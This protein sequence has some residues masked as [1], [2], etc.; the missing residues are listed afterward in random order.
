M[1][2][3]DTWDSAAIKGYGQLTWV[4]GALAMLLKSA[5]ACRAEATAWCDKL[6]I[7]YRIDAARESSVNK[8]IA[9]RYEDNFRYDTPRV[10][11]AVC[12]HTVR[13]WYFQKLS[14]AAVHSNQIS[15]PSMFASVQFV[16]AAC[17]LPQS[18]VQK[19]KV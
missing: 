9:K 5:V 17:L 19:V 13:S 18:V 1:L 6:S 12:A 14:T 7:E 10:C 4:S 2:S 8:K 11:E 16:L 3:S 15:V